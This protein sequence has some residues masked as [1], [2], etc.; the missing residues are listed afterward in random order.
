MILFGRK[1]L[2]MR[3]SWNFWSIPVPA[4]VAELHITFF[5]NVHF[6]PITYKHTL[7]RWFITTLEQ[8]LVR[9]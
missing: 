5:K 6:M 8:D 2:V 1:W 4:G 7:V 9:R 3:N